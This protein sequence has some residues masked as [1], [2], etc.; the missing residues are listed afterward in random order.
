MII[1]GE[2]CTDIVKGECSTCGN[3]HEKIIGS[4]HTCRTDSVRYAIP[5][6]E[7]AWC[8]FRCSG[9]LELIEDTFRR[10]L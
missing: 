4:D 6:D 7:E 1:F 9:C 10:F 2:S 8:V 5:E 3:P